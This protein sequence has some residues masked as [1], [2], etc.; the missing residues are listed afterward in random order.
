MILKHLILLRSR[1]LCNTKIIRLSWHSK[2]YSEWF[3]DECKLLR[4]QRNYCQ[5][6]FD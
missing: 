5:R 6:V 4:R 3:D 1:I 2:C